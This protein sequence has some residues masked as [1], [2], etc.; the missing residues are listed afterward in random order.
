MSY[1]KKIFTPEIKWQRGLTR[2]LKQRL[3]S[4]PSFTGQETPKSEV[5]SEDLQETVESLSK[6]FY[7]IH[8]LLKVYENELETLLNVVTSEDSTAESFGLGQNTQH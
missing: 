8:L 3:L 2:D 1:L 4:M 7:E 6:G 5:S